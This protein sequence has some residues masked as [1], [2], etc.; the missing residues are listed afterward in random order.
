LSPEPVKAGTPLPAAATLPQTLPAVSPL[1]ELNGGQ[2]ARNPSSRFASSRLSPRNRGWSK[3]NKILVG[4]GLACVGLI[5]V[6]GLLFATGVVGA[7]DRYTGPVH[8]VKKE[9]LKITVVARGWLESAKNGDIIC[10]VRSG[11]KGSTTASTIKWLVDNGK[12]VKKGE[13]VMELDDSGLQEALK[14]QNIDTD[15]ASAEWIKAKEQYRIDEIDC[16]IK[17]EQAE[18]ALKLADIDLEKY[19]KGDYAY[20][21][22]DVEGRIKTAES[23]LED[24]KDRAAW[25]ARMAKKGLMSKVQADA[26]ASR[27]DATEIALNKV[28]DEKRVLVD[29]TKNRT[30]QDLRSKLNEAKSNLQKVNIQNE[31]QLALDDAMRKSKKSVYDQQLAKKKEYEAEIVK[32]KVNA[33]QDGL[34]VYYVPDQVRGGGGSQQSI[35]A[36]GEP[37]RE[38]QKMMQI[39]DLNQMLVNTKV[40]E[41]MLAYLREGL[42]CQIRVDTFSN[43]LL[44]GHVKFV[45]NVASQQDWFASD[46]KYY[47]TIVEVENAIDGLKPGMSAEVTI[48]ASENSNPVVQIPIQAVVGSITMDTDRKCFV[49]DADGH[50]QLRDIKVGMS[51]ERMV[52]IKSGLEEGERVALNTQSLLKDFPD[53]KA[54]KAKNSKDNDDIPYGGGGK[55]GGKGDNKGQKAG[56][57]KGALEHRI[58]DLNPRQVAQLNFDRNHVRQDARVQRQE[59]T[60]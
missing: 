28:R 8:V 7:S 5:V 44:K 46:V 20:S 30:E 24:W 53:M 51:N 36:Q 6:A 16:Q 33:P 4:G 50:A 52:E 60:E 48:F 9:R 1:P 42:R 2:T 57:Q 15:N 35:V 41:A 3:Q 26:D 58:L 22:N 12:E 49:V 55:K 11:T 45:D 14:L 37:V 19:L 23:D 25:S 56:D 21:L 13:L 31:A 29:F 39:P 40:P 59:G 17:K 54:G 38:G 43:K 47:K 27:R 32:C 18:N 34:V 10:N